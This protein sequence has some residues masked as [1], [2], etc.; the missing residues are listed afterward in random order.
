MDTYKKGV[1]LAA[2]ASILLGTENIIIKFAY[3]QSNFQ[4]ILITRGIT[5]ILIAAIYI[6]VTKKSF[7]L[8]TKDRASMFIIAIFSII[9]SFLFIYAIKEVTATNASILS[10]MQPVFIILAGL[11]LLGKSGN[12]KKSSYIAII[13]MI[14]AGL[15]IT[16]KSFTNI[17][18]LNIWSI[19]ELLIILSVL[20]SGTADVL[21]KKHFKKLNP[22]LIVFYIYTI[23]SLIFILMFAK[24]LS[25]LSFSWWAVVIGILHIS[26]AVLY[27][28]SI[29]LIKVA[30]VSAIG[31]LVPVTAILL[32][33]IIL[34]EVI[35][36]VQFIGM[37]ILF[38]GF[39]ILTKRKE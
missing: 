18:N 11:I 35:T 21:V 30:K 32:A 4:T 24:H 22:V 37:I 1:L 6:I 3:Q 16:S 10:T 15:V 31:L 28:Q 25:P 13:F 17:I 23:S 8:E 7:R 19:G 14:I 34:K 27:Y 36:L 2:I 5:M 20:A 38:I 29:K 9:S 26:Q 12:L 33:F 39:Y